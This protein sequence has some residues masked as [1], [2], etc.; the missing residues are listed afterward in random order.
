[1]ARAEGAGPL[2]D[3]VGQQQLATRR[4]PQPVG[5]DLER[6]LVGD[7]EEPNLLDRVAPELDPYRVVLGRREDVEDAAP[8]RELA[9]A[10][11]HVDPGVG[12]RRQRPDHAVEVGV[13]A[14]LQRHRNQVAESGRLRLQHAAHRRDD[15]AD[16]PD[17]R[18]VAGR[19]GAAAAARRAGGPRCRPAARAARA[20]SV[21]QAGK[22]TTVLG[23][24]QRTQRGG[25][26]LALPLGGG[27]REHRVAGRRQRRDRERADPARRRDIDLRGADRLRHASKGGV[28]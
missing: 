26:V 9:A 23:G 24:Q 21:S 11:D 1:M 6:A 7:R 4:R 18:V 25:E 27:D 12:D 3:V 17:R 15:H 2:P 8:H 5:R 22:S 19:D 14:G 10:L 16:R 28:G 20:A 13:V